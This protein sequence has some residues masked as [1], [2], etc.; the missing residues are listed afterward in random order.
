ME[1]IGKRMWLHRVEPFKRQKGVVDLEQGFR[2]VFHIYTHAC[3][4]YRPITPL[5]ENLF[6]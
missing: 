3:T 6:C 4:R 5:W 2:T 1:L